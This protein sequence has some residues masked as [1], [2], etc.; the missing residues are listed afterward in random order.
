MKKNSIIIL[1]LLTSLLFSQLDKESAVYDKAYVKERFEI[2]Y[3]E[4]WNFRWND[5]GTPHRVYGDNI[6]YSF[7]VKNADLSE[8]YSRKFIEE[9]EFLFGIDNANLELWVNEM[10]GKMRYLIFNQMY[11]KIHNIIKNVYI[12]T[13]LCNV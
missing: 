7:D 3:S 11:H 12:V 6:P 13:I 9:N 2:K 8:Y 1:T 5:Y 10:G 4:G